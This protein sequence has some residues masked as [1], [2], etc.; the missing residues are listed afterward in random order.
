MGTP[1]KLA[2]PNSIIGGPKYIRVG[3]PAK[4]EG[5][6]TT[7]YYTAMEENNSADDNDSC[8]SGDYQKYIWENTLDWDYT[9]AQYYPL[10]EAADYIEDIIKVTDKACA[11]MEDPEESAAG[12]QAGQNEISPALSELAITPAKGDRNAESK[13]TFSRD[14]TSRDS[15]ESPFS[16]TLLTSPRRES[17]PLNTNIISEASSAAAE[18]QSTKME[19]SM[20][21]KGS[22]STSSAVENDKSNTMREI[23][24]VCFP[25]SVSPLRLLTSSSIVSRQPKIAS[26]HRL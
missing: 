2:N 23:R 16:P 24:E 10:E 7:S 5:S 17:Q 25:L 14:C 12:I 19:P 22:A 20:E 1:T 8:D 21:D 15:S 3:S 4:S 26:L 13:Q 18:I 9:E 11:E 6:G